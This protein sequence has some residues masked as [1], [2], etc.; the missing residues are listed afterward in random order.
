[1]EAAERPPRRDLRRLTRVFGLNTSCSKQEVPE[2][3][4]VDVFAPSQPS[5][6][7]ETRQFH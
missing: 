6:C 7:V 1:M 4:R 2:E 3:I 5:V